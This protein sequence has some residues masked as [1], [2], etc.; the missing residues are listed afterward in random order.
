[1]SEGYIK[2]YRSIQDHWLWKDEP[3]DKARAWI[4]LLMLANW[5]D[6]KISYKG[7]IITCKRGDVNLSFLY[8]AE[9]WNWS[10]WK[11]RNFINLLESDGMVTTNRTTHRT[12]ITLVNYDNFQVSPTTD[13]TTN[14]TT[15]QQ[16]ATTTNKDKNDK[17]ILPKGNRGVFTPPTIDE[18]KAYCFERGN[19][20]DADRWY[21]FYSAKGWMIGKNKMKDWKAAVRTWEKDTKKTDKKPSRNQFNEMIHTDYDFEELERRLTHE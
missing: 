10:T 9:R 3:Y 18:V 4:D 5:E 11:V 21:D 17:N 12:T 6:K 8:L 15:S 7:E 1:M 13:C 20:V 2:L 16:Q 14:H 19:K